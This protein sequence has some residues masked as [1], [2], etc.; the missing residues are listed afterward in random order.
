MKRSNI[1]AKRPALRPA[2]HFLKYLAGYA[3]VSAGCTVRVDGEL[4]F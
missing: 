4:H 2:Q 1:Q 3:G